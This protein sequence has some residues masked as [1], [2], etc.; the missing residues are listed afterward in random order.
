MHQNGFVLSP[1]KTVFIVF[2]K[3]RIP[4]DLSMKVGNQ[5]IK[6]SIHAKYLGCGSPETV[7]GL[8]M[9][10]QTSKAPLER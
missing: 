5:H 10:P 4:P 1:S 2:A 3:S 8:S 6:P 9:C 7:L